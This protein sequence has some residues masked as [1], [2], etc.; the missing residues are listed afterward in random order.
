MTHE[1][2]RGDNGAVCSNG[3]EKLWAYAT[4]VIN[5]KSDELNPYRNPVTKHEHRL[6]S[7]QELLVQRGMRYARCDLETFEVGACENRRKVVD[8]LKEF[9]RDMPV[10][11]RSGDGGLILLGPP[12]TGKDHLLMAA[13][14]AAI[15][16]HGFEVRWVDGLELFSSLKAAI[17]SGDPQKIVKQFSEVPILAISDPV[18]PRA[19][20][21]DYEL[22]MLRQVV[23]R[24][25]NAMR[26]TWITTNVQTAE[27]GDRLLTA[28]VLTRI[29]DG[30]L[31]LFCGWECHRRPFS[32]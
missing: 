8:D 5:R 26:A 29:L 23:D 24:R 7:F 9:V 18:P 12:G 20:L 22:G 4:N 30:A 19:E 32:R 1:M 2:T 6:A 15:L 28:A 21:S 25:Y 14:K 31:H 11:L 17:R 16:N 27:D 13:M 10:R 3:S